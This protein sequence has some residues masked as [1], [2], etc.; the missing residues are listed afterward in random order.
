MNQYS[1]RL[2]R[3]VQFT[4]SIEAGEISASDFRLRNESD[5]QTLLVNSSKLT[6]VTRSLMRELVDFVANRE[7]RANGVC[8]VL[9]SK[10]LSHNCFRIGVKISQ[11]RLRIEIG[12]NKEFDVI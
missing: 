7:I 1:K 3:S 4:L 5:A 11:L 6:D 12:I 2:A 10:W 9:M 8:A